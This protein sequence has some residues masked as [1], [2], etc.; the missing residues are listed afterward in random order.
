[1]KLLHAGLAVIL[2]SQTI[3]SR[4][5]KLDVHVTQPPEHWT[6]IDQEPDSDENGGSGSGSSPVS[7]DDMDETSDH[8]WLKKSKSDQIPHVANSEELEDLLKYIAEQDRRDGSG[9]T[10][11]SQ[12]TLTQMEDGPSKLVEEK[13]KRPRTLPGET[14]VHPEVAGETLEEVDSTNYYPEYAIGILENSCTAFLIGP[15][16]ALTTANCVYNYDMGTWEEEL[17]FWRGRNGDEFLAKMQWEHVVISA[18]YFVKRDGASNWAI[19]TFTEDTA[20]PVWLK[21]A[22]SQSVHDIV[23]TVY[24]Y[25]PDEHPWGVMYNTICRSDYFQND[26]NSLSVQCGT[27]QKFSGGPILK[28]YNFQRSKMAL[29]YG[30]SIAYN[31]SYAHESVNFHPDLFW[32][33]CHLMHKDGFDAKCGSR[34]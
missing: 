9:N 16:H 28:G 34:Q 24:G 11:V 23:M 10:L 32:T 22:Y 29:V 17:D 21:M 33:L 3:L 13:D 19:I 27:G 6:F 7:D 5:V 31:F 20:S 2:L 18:K 8:Q 12:A 4:A 30:I 26:T 15:R 1:M 14:T 25:L